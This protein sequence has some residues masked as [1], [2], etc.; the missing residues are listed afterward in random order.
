MALF[1]DSMVER[2][3]AGRYAAQVPVRSDKIIRRAEKTLLEINFDVSEFAALPAHPFH[4]SMAGDVLG[5]MPE[6]SK[7]DILRLEKYLKPDDANRYF[8]EKRYESD[9]GQEYARTEA[10]KLIALNPVKIETL[11]LLAQRLEELTDIPQ[12]LERGVFILRQ[13]LS[14]YQT[15]PSAV[16]SILKHQHLA[17]VLESLPDLVN[18]QEVCELQKANYRRVYTISGIE[19]N[20]KGLPTTIQLLVASDVAYTSP[21]GGFKVGSRHLGKSVGYL[22]R[23]LADA[24]MANI[25]IQPRDFGAPEK[26]RACIPSIATTPSTTFLE[27]LKLPLL[28]VAAGSGISGIRSILEERAFW[29]SQGHEVGVAKLIFGIH[30]HTKDFLCQEDW[31]RFQALGILETNIQ[32]A[33][34]RSVQGKEKKYVQNVL[35][36]GHFYNDL[37]AIAQHSAAIIICGDWRMGRS[38]LKAYLPFLLPLTRLEQLPTDLQENLHDP[39]RSDLR[40]LFEIGTAKVKSLRDARY[41]CASVSGSRYQK[42]KYTPE[43]EFE[44]FLEELGWDQM[45]GIIARLDLP[46]LA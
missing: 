46:F 30:C 39:R 36:N 1:T 27:K 11:Q 28:L 43:E 34:S 32:L 33:E 9:L 42:R 18:L 44:F 38:L 12:S 14:R 4:Q 8:L 7:E 16:Q 40:R 2:K 23:V 6:N 29:K 17:D 20:E 31:K 22:K 26:Q 13:L 24:S 19:R 10:L 15:E 25:F 3:E 41:I 21:E 37:K 5:V 35:A 45:M